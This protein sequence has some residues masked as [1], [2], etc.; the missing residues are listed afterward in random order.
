MQHMQSVLH[1]TLAKVLHSVECMY[2]TLAKV[3]H[4]VGLH[5]KESFT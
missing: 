2:R 3:I 1:R 4:R 5:F